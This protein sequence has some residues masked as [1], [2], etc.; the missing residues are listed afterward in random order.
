LTNQSNATS[1]LRS[2]MLAAHK[3]LESAIETNDTPAITTAAEKIGQLTTQ[4]IQSHAT[5]EA[6]L[7]G[8]LNPDQLAKFKTLHRHAFGDRFGHAGP[9]AGAPP[10]PPANE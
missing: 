7:R 9:G 4:E 10:P 5:A 2:S 6:A 8:I 1:S 3:A